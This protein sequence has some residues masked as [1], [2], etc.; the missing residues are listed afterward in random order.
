MAADEERQAE[1]FERVETVVGET[2]DIDDG[3]SQLGYGS[4]EPPEDTQR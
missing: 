4:S 2:L 3:Y 1:A